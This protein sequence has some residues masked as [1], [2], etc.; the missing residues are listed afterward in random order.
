MTEEEVEEKE[1]DRRVSLGE[2]GED[3]RRPIAPFASISNEA[4][5]ANI[6]TDLYAAAPEEEADLLGTGVAT[7]ERHLDG[8]RHDTRLQAAVER[9]Y[10]VNGVVVGVDEGDPVAGLEAALAHH[11]TQRLVQQ[12]I[13]YLVGATQQFPV[14]QRHAELAVRIEDRCCRRLVRGR[15]VPVGQFTQI[16]FSLLG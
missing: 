7:R 4:S 14:R 10:E 15:T 5:L 8:H 12:R 3:E 2:R 9:A 16:S 6:Y 13:R 1:E 11:S